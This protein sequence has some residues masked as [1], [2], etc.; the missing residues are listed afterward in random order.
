VRRQV[1]HILWTVCTKMAGE[2]VSPTC[3][4]KLANAKTVI[5]KLRNGP[6]ILTNKQT[7]NRHKSNSRNCTKKIQ[8]DGGKKLLW[9]WKEVMKKMELQ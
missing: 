3:I 9:E 5:M 7:R 1:F 2:T 8:K 4:N 6:L